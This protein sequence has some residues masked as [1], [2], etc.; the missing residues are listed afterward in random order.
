MEDRVIQVARTWIGTRFHHQGRTKGVG[1]D[2]IGLIVGVAKELGLE[3]VDRVDYAREPSNGE[4]E[5]ALAKYLTPCEL[6]VGAVA[7]FKLDKEPQ[8]VGIIGALSIEHGAWNYSLIH[9]YAQARKVVEH[10][11]DDFWKARLVGCFGYRV[12]KS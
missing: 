7:L 4:L 8:H 11:L 2:C 12:D 5:K 3:V 1:V 6:K 10:G 9:A